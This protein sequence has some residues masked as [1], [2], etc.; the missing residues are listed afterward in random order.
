[1]P[2][3]IWSR[4]MKTALRGTAP[5]PLPGVAGGGWFAALPQPQ[6]FAAPNAV[7]VNRSPQ[8]YAA[9]PPSRNNGDRGLDS[10]LLDKLFGSR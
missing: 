5:A 4:F 10:W 6:P 2:V 9:A 3:D 8:P 7:A 1:L